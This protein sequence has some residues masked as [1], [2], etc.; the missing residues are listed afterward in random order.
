MTLGWPARVALRL[1]PES[2]RERYADEVSGTL[3]DVADTHGGSLP[4]VEVWRLG[5][6]GLWR[7][8][9][10]SIV[11]WA[12]IATIIAMA[13]VASLQPLYLPPEAWWTSVLMRAGSGLAAGI[14]AVAA[15]AAWRGG[16]SFRRGRMTPHLRIRAALR[17][18]WPVLVVFAI[19][20]LVLVAMRLGESGWP[21]TA[22]ADLGIPV[23]HFA[24]AIGAIALGYALGSLLPWLLGVGVAPVAIALGLFLPLRG[25][26]PLGGGGWQMAT[27][28]SLLSQPQLTLYDAVNPVALIGVG[29]VATLQLAF[30]L[31]VVAVRPGWWRV[32][33]AIASSALVLGLLT[34]VGPAVSALPGGAVV[35]RAE[36]ELVCAGEAP[37]MCLWPEQE[38]QS[39]P[40]V[41]TTI[42]AMY[43]QLTEFGVAAP[44]TVTS[45]NGSAFIYGWHNYEGAE[46]IAPTGA[47]LLVWV[48]EPTVDRLRL[49][50]IQG[51]VAPKWYYDN[52]ALENISKVSF[53]LALMLGIDSDVALNTVDHPEW[54]EQLQ[55][56]FGIHSLAEAEAL[57]ARWVAGDVP[58][59]PAP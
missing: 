24:M 8:A 19:G 25:F 11:F 35:P 2:W 15:I 4:A 18:T 29:V 39:A 9:R 27:G 23:A 22:S 47:T 54:T 41:R 7:R 6:G 17:D 28:I 3:L 33:P 43:E 53:A 12:G 59:V 50:Y 40:L 20:Y 38:A 36:S 32:L 57:V 5:L 46:A 14:P 21:V 10:G 55:D 34:V 31:V 44:T 1:H 51:L 56:A 49:Q 58:G 37:R 42:G 45:A 30:A 26:E 13:W 48:G 52:A 16:R